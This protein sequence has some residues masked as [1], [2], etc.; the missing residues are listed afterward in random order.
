MAQAP[1]SDTLLTI[2]NTTNP[3]NAG[4]FSP[5]LRGMGQHAKLYN[6]KIWRGMRAYQLAQFPVCNYCAGLGIIKTAN[7]ADHIKP[8]RGNEKL[9][10]DP[11]NLQSLCKKCHD[12]TK[13]REETI[14]RE[15][16]CNT[17]GIPNGREW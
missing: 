16:G 9:F 13:H 11:A 12:S 7:V 1:N 3:H 14:G 2:R 4:F 17:E 10:Y 5:I 8:H 15:I 6:S